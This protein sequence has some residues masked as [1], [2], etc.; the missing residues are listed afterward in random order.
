M[1]R[2]HYVPRFLLKRWATNGQFVS[3]YFEGRPGK[4]IENT[5]ASVASA[6]Q[7]RDLNILF[8][9][10]A[11][12]RDLP[13]TGFFTPHV[14]TPAAAALEVMLARGIRALASEQRMHWARL[15]VSFAVRTPEALRELGPKE[16]ERAFDLVE[17]TAKGPPEDKRKVTAIIQANMQTFKRNFPLNAAKDLSTD[18]EKL[19][20]VDSMAWW[21]R[22]WPRP[23]ILIGDRPLLTVPRA[24]YPCGIP[25]NLRSC[26]IALPIAPDAVFLASANPKTKDRMRAMTPS[27]I[28]RVVNEETI[29][30]ST[31]VYASDESLASFVISRVEGKAKGTWQPSAR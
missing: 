27:K 13:E 19:A 10:H 17:A 5:K 20:A 2:H 24:P 31:C 25:L 11:S 22:R 3:Y 8:G 4:V 15:I 28:A 23:A 26:L 16:T 7:I 18:P 6:C 29:C 14:D 9:V 1:A 12:Q 21:I 30:R